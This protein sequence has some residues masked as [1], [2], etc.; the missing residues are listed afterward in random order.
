[1]DREG[2]LVWSNAATD[3][4]GETF[5]GIT[6]K[7]WAR[8]TAAL[9][10]IIDANK[11]YAD[12]PKCLERDANRQRLLPLVRAFYLEQFW[13]AA[14]IGLL[15]DQKIANEV[16]D[17]AI[18]TGASPAVRFLQDACWA[19]G[20][21]MG[22]AT[23]IVDGRLGP[24]TAGI[25]NAL[26]R[27]VAVRNALLAD[28]NIQQGMWYRSIIHRDPGQRANYRGWLNHRIREDFQ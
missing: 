5:A 9:W 4:G 14:N 23:P 18:N 26:C 25:V 17:T 8:Q 3:R 2:G 22:V 24:A 16:Y 13:D 10:A 12:F 28:L 1:M 11:Q 20:F 27:K 21:G 7:N 6:R 15:D 19:V